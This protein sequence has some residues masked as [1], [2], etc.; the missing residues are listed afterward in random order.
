MIAYTFEPIT[1]M[2]PLQT[3]EHIIHYCASPVF[4]FTFLKHSIDIMFKKIIFFVPPNTGWMVQSSSINALI[5]HLLGFGVGDS[6]SINYCFL[7][8]Y[9]CFFCV[10]FCLLSAKEQSKASNSF[11]LGI[12]NTI[13]WEGDCY[14]TSKWYTSPKNHP[15]IS[16]KHCHFLL[17]TALN[18]CLLN[19]YFF[20]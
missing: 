14:V 5:R 19:N 17:T 11:A 7:F 20:L 13:V 10:C 1:I 12:V 9:L 15:D 18:V 3:D 4:R 6:I 2:K 8:T 16:Y